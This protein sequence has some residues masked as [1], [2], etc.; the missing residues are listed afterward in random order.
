[1]REIKYKPGKETGEPPG[2]TFGG[3]NEEKLFG[4]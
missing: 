4:G 1:M 3:G 2:K